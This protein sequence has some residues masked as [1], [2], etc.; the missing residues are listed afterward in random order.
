MYFAPGTWST[1]DPKFDILDME[2][3]PLMNLIEQRSTLA[4]DCPAFQCSLAQLATMSAAM[5]LFVFLV[6][7]IAT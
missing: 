1:A 3:S 6:A 2:E 4:P 7:F 5:L